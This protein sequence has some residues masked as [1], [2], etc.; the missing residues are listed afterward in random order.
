MLPNEKGAAPRFLYVGR[1]VPEKGV[2][3]LLAAYTKY[4]EATTEPWPLECV[5]TGP[6]AGSIRAMPGTVDFGFVQPDRLPALLHARPGAFV[7]SSRVEPW[8]VALQEAGAAGLPLVCSDA[9]GAGVHLVQD[10]Y[11]GFLFEAGNV[12]HLMRRLL[13][14]ASLSPADRLAMARASYE[15]SRQFTPARWADTLVEGIRTWGPSGMA[16]LRIRA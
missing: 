9:S 7:F 10:G 12:E 8:G 5:G 16:N 11:N 15:L 2:D 14:M 4:R 6:L 13:Q 3:D 1:Y